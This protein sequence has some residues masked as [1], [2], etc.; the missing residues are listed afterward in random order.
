MKRVS[1]SDVDQRF[2]DMAEIFN[3]QQERHESMVRHIKNVQHCYGCNYTDSLA[4]EECVGKIKK[5]HGKWWKYIKAAV[6]SCFLCSMF[7]SFYPL[8]EAKYKIFLKLSGY[9]FSLNVV[10]LGSAGEQPFPPHLKLAQDEFKG[11]SESAKATISKGTTL[12]EL[13]SCLLRRQD[14]MAEQ[15]KG[16]AENHQTLRRLNKN[17][18]DNMKEVRRAKAL[19]KVY[20]QQVGEVLTEVADIAGAFL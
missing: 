3:Q 6:I 8:P 2:S 17:L 9:D 14:Q 12:Q 15:V 13:I 11:A 19:S 7:I 1:V 4:L 18:E 10:P 5:E 20:K 16:A